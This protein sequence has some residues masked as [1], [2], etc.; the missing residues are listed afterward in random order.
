MNK[1]EFE[2]EVK[3]IREEKDLKE[4]ERLAKELNDKATREH[5]KN[6]WN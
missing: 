4:K 5:L 6:L 3:R 1:E 2:K